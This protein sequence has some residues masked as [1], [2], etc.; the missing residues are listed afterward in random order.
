MSD[1]RP[2]R[3]KRAPP[4][5]RS[6]QRRAHRV[7]ARRGHHLGVDRHHLRG[8]ALG[9][10]TWWPPSSPSLGARGVAPP[11]CATATATRRS[12]TSAASSRRAIIFAAAVVIIFEA[13]RH[14][15]GRDARPHPPGHRRDARLG[16][17]NLGLTLVPVPGRPAHRLARPRGRRR[18]PPDRRVHLVRRGRR[19]A[20]GRGHR[21]HLLRPPG[22]HRG[23]GAHHLDGLA[24]WS[25]GPPACCSTRRC[26][27]T[28]SPIVRATVAE[29]RG[30][31]ICGYHKLRARHAGARHR[32]TCMSRCPTT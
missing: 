27:T 12:R 16:G 18:P 9:L 5:C 14:D 21:P 13:V 2:R 24:E 28:S 23:G 10:P 3:R 4:R 7:Q 17:V 30:E 11:T 15:L 32:S 6:R 8:G 29:H 22:R 25:A 1:C 31:L 20:A 26:P 19:P